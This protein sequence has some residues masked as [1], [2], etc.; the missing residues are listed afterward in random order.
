MILKREKIDCPQVLQMYLSAIDGLQSIKF[1]FAFIHVYSQV[2][3]VFSECP[4]QVD[5]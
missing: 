3:Q 4:L 5:P 1:K 2:E